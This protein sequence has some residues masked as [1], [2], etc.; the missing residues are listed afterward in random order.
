[1]RTPTAA[2]L[3]KRAT[4]VAPAA[5]R[6]LGHAYVD[7]CRHCNESIVLR[8]DELNAARPL[9]RHRDH[10]YRRTC[11]ERALTKHREWVKRHPERY[12]ASR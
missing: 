9:W 7:F 5:R 6:R 10:G 12:L 3:G 4:P 2:P 11:P 1:M 8:T